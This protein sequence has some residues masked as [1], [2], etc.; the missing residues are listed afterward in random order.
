MI[1]CEIMEQMVDSSDNFALNLIKSLIRSSKN[2]KPNVLTSQLFL[3]R[4]GC[5]QILT[6]VGLYLLFT[7]A[8]GPKL[9]TNRTAFQLRRTIQIYNIFMVAINLYFF[10][11]S[12]IAYEFGTA[13]LNFKYPSNDNRDLSPEDQR[14][15][16]FV[17]WYL[18]SK[19][20]DLMDT[21][22]FVLRK[23][24]S[25]VS[26][27]HLYHHSS[28]PLCVWLAVCYAPTAGV[29]GIFP[30]INSAV[31]VLMYTY[32]ALSALGPK[33]QKYL[34]WKR[35]ITIIQ[36]AQFVVFFVYGLTYLIKQ[37]GWPSILIAT[38]VA[39]PP[40]YLFMF[41]SFY[42]NTY[43]GP[44]NGTNDPHKRCEPELKSSSLKSE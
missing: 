43:C 26:A 18:M 41:T 1:L 11:A 25:Q 15:L 9:M 17:Y 28:V 7:L 39:Q 32:Y 29:N 20:L 44:K 16:S 8:I 31:H 10:F 6:I 35:Y 5:W 34:W 3:F 33:V 40:L 24:W 12:I 13:L 38:S 27:L 4:S 21:V 19:I 42:V 2:L 14:R 23:K 37:N 36:L 22:F 30:I